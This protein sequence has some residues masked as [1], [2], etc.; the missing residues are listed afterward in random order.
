MKLGN[1]KLGSCETRRKLSEMRIKP[2]KCKCGGW[3]TERNMH[4]HKCKL[5]ADKAKPP[6][7]TKKERVSQYAVRYGVDDD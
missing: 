4:I 5:D 3:L 6:K 1:V 2:R 7:K